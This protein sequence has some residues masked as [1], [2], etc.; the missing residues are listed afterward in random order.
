MNTGD[1]IITFTVRRSWLMAVVWLT[2]GAG[3]GFA[4]ASVLQKGTVMADVGRPVAVGGLAQPGAPAPGSLRV[5]VATDGRPSVGPRE[6]PVTI[7]EFTDY[8]CPFC[9]RHSQNTK[10]QLMAAYEGKVR[11][12]V[13]HFPLTSIHPLAHRAAEAAECALDQ[14]KFWEYSELLYSRAPAFADDQLKGYAAELGLDG[15]RFIRCLESGEK[16]QVVE[17]DVREGSG[18][19][20]QSTPTFFING[21]VVQ[22]AQPLAQFQAIVDAAMSATAQ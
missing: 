16:T 4:A 13:R 6:A 9:A 11:Y 2:V 20:V 19:G 10:G 12:V 17:R 15:G 21:Q 8:Q 14:G 1:D 3:G 5:E 18:Y 7:V 22:G